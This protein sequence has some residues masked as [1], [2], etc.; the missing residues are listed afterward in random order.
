[1]ADAPGLG[2]GVFG[3]EGS[4]PS[5]RTDWL[6]LEMPVAWSYVRNDVR[7][8][9]MTWDAQPI[10]GFQFTGAHSSPIG[11]GLDIGHAVE[12]THGRDE[13]PEDREQTADRGDHQCRPQSDHGAEQTAGE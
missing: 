12:G 9:R 10:I 7:D 5:A 11:V 13:H 2:P 1:M 6:A 3:R 8:E 4:T